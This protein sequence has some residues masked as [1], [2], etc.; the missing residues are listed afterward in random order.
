MFLNVSL[1]MSQFILN[2]IGMKMFLYN[3]DRI[4]KNAKSVIVVS[5]HRS[6]LDAFILIQALNRPIRIA[7][8]Q[9]MGQT[10][11]LREFIDFLGFF[12]LENSQ[13]RGKLF[14]DY[15]TKLLQSQEWVGIFPEG[16]KPM[17]KLTSP[18][19]ITSFQRGFAHLAL[20]ASLPNLVVLPVAIA[21][22]SESIH[23]GMPLRWLQLFDGTEPLFDAP[24][25]H[26]VV[27]YER[28]NVLI[29]NPYWIDKKLKTQYLGGETKKAVNHLLEYAQ[30]EITQL[31]KIGC[32]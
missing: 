28:V 25:L 11:I 13:N 17:V 24:N 14:L 15:S 7:C 6:F 32:A 3:Q 22:T 12:A 16:A 8:H 20:K 5:N 21:S 18:E 4:P 31:L 19:K 26:P 29:G 27:M 1:L 30:E 10:P 23:S 9:Y 2:G